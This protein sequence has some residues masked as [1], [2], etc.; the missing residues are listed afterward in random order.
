M[1][2]Y[3]TQLLATIGCLCFGAW[4]MSLLDGGK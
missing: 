3:E 1:T 2:L 4:F